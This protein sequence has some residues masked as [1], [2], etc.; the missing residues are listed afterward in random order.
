MLLQECRELV[1]LLQDSGY[2]ITSL[3]DLDDKAYEKASQQFGKSHPHLCRRMK[4]VLYMC[5]HF[6]R[7]DT[8]HV[9][10]SFWG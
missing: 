6:G 3:G 2:E 1:K 8:H 10:L 5:V 7:P 4:F 9:T